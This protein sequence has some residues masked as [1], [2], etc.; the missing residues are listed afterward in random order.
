MNLSFN[1]SGECEDEIYPLARVGFGP[2]GPA[3]LFDDLLCDTS[4][5]RY[6]G[7]PSHRRQA[8]QTAEKEARS[9]QETTPGL[10]SRPQTDTA[11]LPV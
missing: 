11:S 7:I 3:M 2:D 8:A 5:A 4:P 10:H 9:H 6:S 1:L